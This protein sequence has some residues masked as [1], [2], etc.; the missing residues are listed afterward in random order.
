[1]YMYITLRWCIASLARNSRMLD[2]S[3]AR[4]KAQPHKTVINYAFTTSCA[5]ARVCV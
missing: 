5:R 2:R 3:T 4:P 1:M